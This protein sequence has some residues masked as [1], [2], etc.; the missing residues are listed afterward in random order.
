MIS[1]FGLF[2]PVKTE[3][4]EDLQ[5]NQ[6]SNNIHHTFLCNTYRHCLFSFLL[7]LKVHSCFVK[8]IKLNLISEFG[9]QK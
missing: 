3:N 7:V 4:I 2:I 6:S 8:P 1:T 9:Y 5:T